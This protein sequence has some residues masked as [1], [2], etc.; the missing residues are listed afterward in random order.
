MPSTDGFAKEASGDTYGTLLGVRY[1]KGTGVKQLF[2][3]ALIGLGL[4]GLRIVADLALAL[5]L[6]YKDTWALI[7]TSLLDL[8]LS[9]FASLAARYA[10]TS[11]SPNTVLFAA[12]S[13]LEAALFSTI[14]LVAVIVDVCRA[15]KECPTA[16]GCSDVEA[17]IASHGASAEMFSKGLFDKGS[18]E[19]R[20][21]RGLGFWG[22]G[23]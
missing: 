13:F 22:L 17:A 23:F 19:F 11:P 16:A 21:Y 18:A 7:F 6:R 4:S 8:A 14:Y 12:V 9:L 20:V 5:S 3:C 1:A 15:W 10:V 2:Y